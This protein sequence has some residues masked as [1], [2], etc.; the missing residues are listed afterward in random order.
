VQPCSAGQQSFDIN[1]Y[2]GNVI[3]INCQDY[4]KDTIH[5]QENYNS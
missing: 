5:Y 3:V 1:I 2:G 4:L